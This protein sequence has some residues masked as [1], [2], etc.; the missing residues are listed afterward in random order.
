MMQTFARFFDLMPMQIDAPGGTHL[1]ATK[2]FDDAILKSMDRI[3]QRAFGSNP[4]VG[5]MD[6]DV[7]VGVV[8]VRDG[9][10]GGI[11]DLADTFAEQGLVFRVN[12]VV[13]GFMRI[14]GLLIIQGE[15]HYARIFATRMHLNHN[16]SFVLTGQW[17]GHEAI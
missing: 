7:M 2:F 8:F 11:G 17:S 6:M 3:K 12:R 13:H 1:S 4:C 16:I 10:W 5:L 9:A 15:R 14:N